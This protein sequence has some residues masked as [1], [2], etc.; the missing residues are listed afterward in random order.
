MNK[1]RDFRVWLEQFWMDNC[2]E[3]MWWGE[4]RLTQ[5]DF[6]RQYKWILKREYRHQTRQIDKNTKFV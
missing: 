3:R 1:P 5:A 4:P 6:F 2:D